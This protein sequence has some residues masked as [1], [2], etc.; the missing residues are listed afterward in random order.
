[1][2]GYDKL[3]K[4]ADIISTKCINY[5]PNESVLLVS[6][7]LQSG[8]LIDIMFDSL[9]RHGFDCQV[10]LMQARKY[11]GQEPPEPVQ[12]A[13]LA[14]N[15]VIS[16]PV[17][18]ITYSNTVTRAREAGTRFLVATAITEEIFGNLIALEDY[19]EIAAKTHEAAE[20]LAS[21][22]S[23][24]ITSQAGT[25]VSMKLRSGPGLAIDGIVRRPSDMS[26]L[27]PGTAHIA[28]VEGS[29]EGI[30]TIDGSL[31]PLG[32]LTDPVKLTVEKGFVTEI[33][34]SGTNARKYEEFLKGFADPN[35]FAIAEVGFGLNP[36]ARLSGMAIVDERIVGSA[37]VGIGRSIQIGGKIN[38]K[39]HTD[40]VML[41]PTLKIDERTV[42][43]GG[44]LVL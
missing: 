32:I 41:N 5:K 24:T 21:A 3:V 1:M 22:K 23:V 43:D 17:G 44:K 4:A 12:K 10:A 15:I 14:S 27:P 7:N 42:V 2:V 9:N 38:A 40:A 28:P 19:D 8:K 16:M 39:T 13:I 11:P 6:D 36:A 35:V 30:L 31:V 34:G 29:C 33:A 18:S 26:Y 20:M 37:F 25:N